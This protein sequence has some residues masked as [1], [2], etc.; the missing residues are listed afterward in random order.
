MESKNKFIEDKIKAKGEIER[1]DKI[2]WGLFLIMLGA[3]WLVPESML[4]NG[5]F[6]FGVGIILL[7]MNYIKYSK[8][9]KVNKFTVFVGIVALIAGA[10][11][12]VGQPIDILPLILILWGI[13]ILF[14]FGKKRQDEL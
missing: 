11:A 4:P 13:S 2:G 3:L 6:V 9:Y 12:L 10:S 7:G 14:G 5:I 8:G 1:L